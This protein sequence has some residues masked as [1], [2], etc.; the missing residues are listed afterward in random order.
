MAENKNALWC[1]L[2][3]I[4]IQRWDGGQFREGVPGAYNQ[5][6]RVDVANGETGARPVPVS[7]CVKEYCMFYRKSFDRESCK[8][9]QQANPGPWIFASAIAIGMIA[10]FAKFF[11]AGPLP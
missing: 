4:S 3:R 5:I 7:P 10:I 6:V 8:L 9:G 2:A 11:L 1:P